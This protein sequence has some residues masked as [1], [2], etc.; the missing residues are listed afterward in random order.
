M[1]GCGGDPSASLEGIQKNLA[2][3]QY[4]PP[5]DL[6]RWSEAK[7]VRWNPMR[8]PGE[9]LIIT[10]VPGG[11]IDSYLDDERLTL[12]LN[13]HWIAI[14]LHPRARPSLTGHLG[15]PSAAFVD[16]KGCIYAHGSP[17]SVEDF[18]ALAEKAT[19]A[20]EAGETSALPPYDYDTPP[21]PAGG[22]D[23]TADSPKPAAVFVQPDRGAP[24][25][26]VD[27]K[28]Y[29]YGNRADAELFD[30]RPAAAAFLEELPEKHHYKPDEGPIFQCPHPIPPPIGTPP[31][32]EGEEGEA[33]EGDGGEQAKPPAGG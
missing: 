25:V 22:G 14:F 27:G 31:V 23:W 24:A 15:W 3:R 17:S 29:V 21:P 13:K 26:L 10:D 6:P 7:F 20:K 8:T 11:A 32:P 5:S 4:D 18:V 28:P 19:A 1:M 33:T 9:R 12:T 16:E 30:K 2:R